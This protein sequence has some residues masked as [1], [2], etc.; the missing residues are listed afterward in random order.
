[1]DE[2]DQGNDGGTRLAC[3]QVPAG[4][5]VVHTQEAYDLYTHRRSSYCIHAG[6][7]PI[8]YKIEAYPLYTCM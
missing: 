5:S 1:M 4:A 7:L 3:V 8:I 2:C 6:G